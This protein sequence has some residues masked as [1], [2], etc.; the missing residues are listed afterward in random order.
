MHLINAM[1]Y[2]NKIW[3]GHSSEDFTAGDEG[4]V[5]ILFCLK[6]NSQNDKA[7]LQFRRCWRHSFYIHCR[8]STSV[9]VRRVEQ[10]WK[11]AENAVC[12][13]GGPG[14]D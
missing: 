4:F 11:A 9:G 8:Q 2:N 14:Y 10:G 13:M 3:S 5:Q 12:G 6:L 1:Q 7:P